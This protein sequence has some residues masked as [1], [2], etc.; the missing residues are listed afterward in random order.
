MLSLRRVAADKLARTSVQAPP[1]STF[2]SSPSRL[3]CPDA[4]DRT[5][6]IFS[7]WLN[8]SVVVADACLA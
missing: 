5:I 1:D 6:D 2:P 7:H 8:K 4:F 3:D